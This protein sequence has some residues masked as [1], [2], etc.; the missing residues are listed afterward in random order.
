MTTRYD[1]EEAPALEELNL[2]Y[3]AD[4]PGAAVIIAAGIGVFVRG[5]M[6]ILSELSA[7][8]R[9]FLGDTMA[10]GQPVGPLASKSILAT[11]AFFIS[12]GVLGYL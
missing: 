1:I 8:I 9:D 5:L 2:P 6:T 12:W 7:G 3:K 4:G 10:F 11:L